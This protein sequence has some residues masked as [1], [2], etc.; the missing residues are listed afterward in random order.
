MDTIFLIKFEHFI[1]VLTI[2]IDAE[3]CRAFSILKLQ[4]F[5]IANTA[6]MRRAPLFI[7]RPSFN[8]DPLPGIPC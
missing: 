7:F 4:T 8:L 2:A 5:L 6:S 1:Y 3:N